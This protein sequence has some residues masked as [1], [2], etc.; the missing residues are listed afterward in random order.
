VK[1]QEDKLAVELI[2]MREELTAEF[3][4]IQIMRE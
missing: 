1:S 3:N 4:K 2:K